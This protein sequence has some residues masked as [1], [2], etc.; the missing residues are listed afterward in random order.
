MANAAGAGRTGPTVKWRAAR[1]VRTVAGW[2]ARVERVT[3]PV[4]PAT[5]A[6]LDRRW[7]QLPEAVR[8][9]DQALGRSGVTCEG[10]HG[11]FPACNFACR[12]CY[13][14]ADANRVRVDGPHTLAEVEAQMSLCVELGAPFGHAQLIG[15][16]VSL[17]DADTHAEAL[18]IMRRHGREP[19]SFTHGDFDYDYLERIALDPSGR[20]R[21][22]RLSFAAHFDTTMIGRS[23]I[24][25]ARRES[26]LD[27]YRQEFCDMFAHLRAEH[28]VRYYLAH[29]MTVTPDNVD[30]IPGVVAR[31]RSM[32]FNMFSF[33]P[34]AHVGDPR[35]WKADYQ[36]IDAEQVWT[37]IEQGAG[38]RLPWRVFQIGHPDCNRTAWGFYLGDRWH[39]VLDPDDP[40]DMAVR[41]AVYR[42]L[43]GVH[44]NAPPRLL[45]PRLARAVIA[46]PN[47]LCIALGWA[48]RTIRRVG[49]PVTLLRHR[50]V[51]MTFV[52]HRF[53]H[54][55]D[56]EPA[57][58]LL[59]RGE[60]SP[61]PDVAHTQERLLAC[62]YVMGHPET[63]RL[64]PACVQ[65]SVLDPQEN[66]QLSQLL[67][68][69]TVRGRLR[70]RG[71][72]EPSDA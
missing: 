56:V 57:W 36:R 13:H 66:R 17:L 28:R 32:G 5:R 67:P 46:H 52:M 9:P 26:D 20:P 34:A 61:D 8:I 50:I 59:E 11:V 42:H 30:Q 10:T 33:Q 18:A 69:P 51:P 3:R 19:M 70:Q 72:P 7:A 22:R 23:G 31:G 45:A 44:F 54:A 35:R 41:E 49:G 4:D 64:I 12:P 2:L 71:A 65:H 43:G 58:E 6:A 47:L 25:R 53:M 16:E 14:S 37:R 24:R 29:N 38:C 15:G 1:H 62:S 39:S 21:F 60:T 68:L 27:P 48:A 63:G 55:E 40:N